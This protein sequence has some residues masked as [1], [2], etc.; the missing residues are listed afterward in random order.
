MTS[1][2]KRA[3]PEKKTDEQ[4]KGFLERY[5]RA[6]VAANAWINEDVA[7][8]TDAI[9][10]LP[11][12][13][14]VQI[15]EE[16]PVTLSEHQKQLLGMNDEAIW[17]G[18]RESSDSRVT[19]RERA[20]TDVSRY[21][22]AQADQFDVLS[23]MRRIEKEER[24]NDRWGKLPP[25]AWGRI[26]F[27]LNSS[28]TMS[29]LSLS[30]A[31]RHQARINSTFGYVLSA[32]VVGVLKCLPV[33]H[34]AVKIWG[35]FPWGPDLKLCS[36]TNCPQDELVEVSLGGWKRQ[37][38]EPYQSIH[39][40][41]AGRYIKRL[42]FTD[43]AKSSYDGI[44]SL[45][46]RMIACGSVSS[47]E[48]KRVRYERTTAFRTW[49]MNSAPLWGA[50]GATHHAYCESFTFCQL[51]GASSLSPQPIWTLLD[52]ISLA[53]SLEFARDPQPSDSDDSDSD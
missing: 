16:D 27:H 4:K 28:D 17:R 3:R 11:I 36:T 23:V 37:H 35:E 15:G 29:L 46:Q 42:G 41:Y 51:N 22:H 2:N 12:R 50:A 53:Q 5:V 38:G 45:L 7:L 47:V 31:V 9:R 48:F 6:C 26:L 24:G 32:L 30:S 34:V 49:W 44:R 20:L 25:T 33:G 43:R 14:T 52:R 19:T 10:F 8:E 1:A 13:V 39:T 18:L 21:L 40:S